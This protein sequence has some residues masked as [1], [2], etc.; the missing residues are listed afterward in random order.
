MGNL[1]EWH[2]GKFSDNGDNEDDYFVEVKEDDNDNDNDNK[3][4]NIK[5]GWNFNIDEI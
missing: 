3:N 1:Y 4:I 2:F 5:Y